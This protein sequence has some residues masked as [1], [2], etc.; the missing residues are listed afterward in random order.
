MKPTTL[1]FPIDSDNRILLGRKKR[2]FGADKYNGFGGKIQRGENFRACAVRE[3]YEESGIR[4]SPDDLECVAFFDFQF[5]YDESLTHVGYVYFVHVH[6]VTAIESD[7]ME[8]HWFHIDTIPYEHM[9]AGDRTWLPLLLQ[10]RKLK[11]PI[12]F[13]PDNSDVASMKLIDVD[14]VIES[15]L[16]DSIDLY[17][18]E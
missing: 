14:M 18:N 3:L 17:I 4:V 9:W 15:E 8:P 10:G 1:V 16:L 13:G 2:G 6:H 5:P 7:E 12:V 11:G